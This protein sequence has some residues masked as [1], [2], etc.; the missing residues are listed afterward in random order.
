[1]C[2]CRSA[3]AATADTA[4]A[5]V[6]LRL[7]IAATT[8]AAGIVVV[9]GPYAIYIFKNI[10]MYACA[11]IGAKTPRDIIASAC[12]TTAAGTMIQY[13]GTI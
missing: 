1:M 6:V 10:A 7:E 13:A 8:A 12:C 3:V 2:R 11:A 5:F 4:R 9:I